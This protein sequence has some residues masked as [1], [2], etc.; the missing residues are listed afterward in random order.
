MDRL[1]RIAREEKA[2]HER[3]MARRK[4]EIDEE[5]KAIAAALDAAIAEKE[6]KR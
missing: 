3:E 1:L 4:K 2:A 5:N 6:K